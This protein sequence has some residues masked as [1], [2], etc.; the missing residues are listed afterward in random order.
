MSTFDPA[1]ALRIDLARGQLTLL[2]SG[3]RMLVP[4]ESLIDLLAASDH[5]A[6]AAFGASIGTGIGRRITDR[7]GASIEQASVELFTEHLGGELALCG[8]GSLSVERWGHAMVLAIEGLKD[9]AALE[10]LVS[11]LIEAALQRALSRDV[12]V[13]SFGRKDNVLRLSLLSHHAKDLVESAMTTGK[14]YGEVLTLLHES[15]QTT[16]STGNATRGES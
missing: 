10:L 15:I 16:N 11:A 8:L 1:Q 3:D 5:D 7:L 9:S 14:S 13:V 6:I 12:S 2:G 4:L